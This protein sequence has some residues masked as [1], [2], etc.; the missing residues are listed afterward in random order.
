[1]E[2]HVS[3][4]QIQ[5][6]SD[7]ELI[8]YDV[9][10]S[11]EVRKKH[12]KTYYP[13]EVTK[14]LGHNRYNIKYK[15]GTIEDGVHSQYMKMLWGK[16]EN[17]ETSSQ[18]STSSVGN[19][20]KYYTAAAPTP[21]IAPDSVMKR[22]LS[23]SKS[24]NNSFS[25]S[26][27][28]IFSSIN[29]PSIPGKIIGFTAS[30]IISEPAS[31]VKAPSTLQPFSPSS[32]SNNQHD[33]N[34]K[35][36][37][38][39]NIGNS[40]VYINNTLP[41]YSCVVLS[42]NERTKLYTLRASDEC[43][44][45]YDKVPSIC[46]SPINHR[47]NKVYQ[48][49]ERVLSHFIKDVNWLAGYVT[50]YNEN[51]QMYTVLFD[52]NVELESVAPNMTSFPQDILL[53]KFEIQD[54]VLT[55]YNCNS[56]Q[57]GTILSK[58]EFDR[59]RIELENG[60]MFRNVHSS[61][62]AL[63]EIG[64]EETEYSINYPTVLSN[65]EELLKLYNTPFEYND[66]VLGRY[67]EKDEWFKGKIVDKDI[68]NTIY[69]ILYDDGE[70]EYDMKPC[71]ICHYVGFKQYQRG[72][73][74]LCEFQGKACLWCLATIWS[75]DFKNGTYKVMF[76]N[77]HLDSN[78]HISQICRI[79][80][81]KFNRTFQKDMKVLAKYD[82]GND[83]YYSGI[84]T[85]VNGNHYCISY[86]DGDHRD[87]IHAS[88]IKP[89]EEISKDP[90]IEPSPVEVKQEEF[91]DLYLN[92]FK[93]D[94][95]VLAKLNEE[96]DGWYKGKILSRIGSSIYK[97]DF[98]NG[99][100]N[101]EV[102]SD[103]IKH[104]VRYSEIHEGDRILSEYIEDNQWYLATI[105]DLTAENNIYQIIYDNGE[106]VNRDISKI[107]SIISFDFIGKFENNLKVKSRT[108]FD[109]DN[110]LNGIIVGG[111]GDNYHIKFDTGVT[112][113]YIHASFIKIGE[114]NLPFYK[115]S[116]NSSHRMTIEQQNS[117]DNLPGESEMCET[118]IPFES[119]KS[120]DS[121]K[122]NSQIFKET[123]TFETQ[124]SGPSI[125]MQTQTTPRL[126]PKVYSPRDHIIIDH[127][128]TQTEYETQQNMTQTGYENGVD[129]E[130]SVDPNAFINEYAIQ[131]SPRL[132]EETTFSENASQTSPLP[133]ADSSDGEAQTLGYAPNINY[134]VQT[135][136]PNFMVSRHNQTDDI[137]PLPRAKQNKPKR[138]EELPTVV[139]DNTYEK[140]Y[141][142][143]YN[144]DEVILGRYKGL[145]EWFKGKI[146]EKDEQLN[147]YKLFYDNGL[148]E[149]NVDEENI[150]H[151]ITVKNLQIDDR[152]LCQYSEGNKWYLGTIY[153]GKN[154]EDGTYKVM[155]DN[156]DVISQVSKRICKIPQEKLDKYELDM[157]VVSR[158]D[159]NDN[160][161]YI[162]KIIRVQGDRYNIHF[163]NGK[164]KE[165]IYGSLIYGEL[166]ANE[167]SI[168]VYSSSSHKSLL[169][170]TPKQQHIKAVQGIH[171]YSYSPNFSSTGGSNGSKSLSQSQQFQPAPGILVKTL[172]QEIS[173]LKDT[174]TSLNQRLI[175]L[176]SP[177][178]DHSYPSRPQSAF[179]S[180]DSPSYTDNSYTTYSRTTNKMSGSSY[181]R[182]ESASSYSSTSYTR[183][184]TASS[185]Q[186]SSENGT[187]TTGQ[188]TTTYPTTT[189]VSTTT[190][191][192][193][194]TKQSA[195]TTG[196][197]ATRQTTTITEGQTTTT[198]KTG[199]TATTTTTGVS[200]TTRPTTAT[201]TT[202]TATSTTTGMLPPNYPYYYNPTQFV[203][204]TPVSMSSATPSSVSMTSASTQQQ[205]QQQL[206]A[207]KSPQSAFS[208]STS[209]TQTTVSATG[210][211][212]TAT[213]TTNAGPTFFV[214]SSPSSQ[215]PPPGS[216][217]VPIQC[218]TPTPQL[219]P[220]M[221]PQYGSQF[222]QITPI[223]S[224][225]QKSRESSLNRASPGSTGSVP[226]LA[227]Y[228]PS[229]VAFPLRPAAAK[230]LR[231][232]DSD[233]SSTSSTTD[234]GSYS[235]RSST[236]GSSYTTTSTVSTKL[237]DYTS[238]EED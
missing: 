113:E 162:G 132:Y 58:N 199:T 213:N 186:S 15:D 61:Y 138:L 227:T 108:D 141:N 135:A 77:G 224:N 56:F 18:S 1:M 14:V 29:A 16:D 6:L 178:S 119:Y 59:Y 12:K 157:K 200:T 134:G 142:R 28:N 232:Y 37:F 203:M 76:D 140:F 185:E 31:P 177:Y 228:V 237:E 50:S 17:P 111:K 81:D 115:T 72:D 88:F 160:N 175:E 9:G 38:H 172:E 198:G 215:P 73:R 94:E 32:H 63:P 95:T 169:V 112:K 102:K 218:I 229:G 99:Y 30:G 8:V 161:R 53:Q 3:A 82:F 47:G 33:D 92:P 105:W 65:E 143:A 98:E 40:V 110:Y 122:H 171:N 21:M 106:L 191:Q 136:P 194:T 48:I 131:T 109:D 51:T 44:T 139:A 5:G 133:E 89:V 70:S 127:I 74:V 147:T 64:D 13:G 67:Q 159:F 167:D 49:G 217:M 83:D 201:T 87:N 46:L 86:E 158:I 151:Y 211:T 155:F 214:Q 19:D 120:L 60:A 57:K 79:P 71:N 226:V 183:P 225:A 152:V 180:H 209:P 43:C 202:T 196:T 121:P 146:V 97:I 10:D 36:D 22:K 163:D 174:I 52:N 220:P 181:T 204:M 11:V 197:T 189:G 154:E 233:T 118:T 153:K 125:V 96:K 235:S 236:S 26:D 222:M 187:T 117:V 126:P 4:S 148:D 230:L 34:N 129:V 219:G 35:K 27:S 205:Q 91:D 170:L 176:E 84:I 156:G 206:K 179:G 208:Q 188:S 23:M 69:K 149:I 130:C 207:F 221:T 164:I 173:S 75:D 24:L 7:E 193:S 195:A 107:C 184:Q 114:G 68:H 2:E 54:I 90:I 144:V 238:S 123:K 234:D 150:R 55:S 216:V 210:T 20:R 124:T 192:T 104:F 231:G 101:I 66:T 137:K 100:K 85:A 145:D 42:Y 39:Y 212:T 25:A 62:I 41:Y 93:K 168:S 190:G 103:N 80:Q 166:G 128:E 223:K 45:I 116:I 78:I 165:N 182:P